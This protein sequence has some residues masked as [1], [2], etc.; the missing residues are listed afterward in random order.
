M[1]IV[2]V[3]T[4]ALHCT[5]SVTKWMHHTA[6]INAIGRHSQN[7]V[8]KKST[9]LFQKCDVKSSSSDEDNDDDHGG[10]NYFV[11]HFL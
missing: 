3:N 10:N 2:C 1:E 11:Q 7:D 4:I 6:F 9:Q 5:V 8:Y